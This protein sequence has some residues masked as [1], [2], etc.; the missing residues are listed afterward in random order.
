MRASPVVVL[1][2]YDEN[3]EER[4]LSRVASLG[5]RVRW[6]RRSR[7]DEPYRPLLRTARPS[8]RIQN[9]TLRI[10]RGGIAG[11]MSARVLGKRGPIGEL[12]QASDAEAKWEALVEQAPDGIFVTDLEGRYIEVNAAGCRMLGYDHDELI[13]KT[14]VDLIPPEDV[15]RLWQSRD[16]L[17]EGGTHVGEWTLRTKRGTSFPVEVS[18]RILPDGRWQGLVRDISERRR[19]AERADHVREGLLKSE[20]RF[21]LAFEEAPIGMALVGLDGS[22]VR[23]NQA[24]CE[25]VGYGADELTGRTFQEITYPADLDIDLDLANRLYRGEIPRYQLEKRYVRKDGAIVNVMLSGSMVRDP[26][27]EPL[28]YIAQIEDITER[29][30]IEAEQRFLAEAGPVLAAATMDYEQT[31][32]KIAELAVRDLADVCIVDVVG[33]DGEVRRLQVLDRT[34]NMDWVRDALMRIPLDRKRPHL[35]WSALE[36]KEP[37]LI[38]DVTPGDIAQWAQSDEHFRALRGLAAR[39]VITV[40]LLAH[41]R[42]LGALTLVSSTRRYGSA[43]LRLA[44]ELAHRAALSIENA[45]LYLV[46]KQAVQTRDEVLGIVAHDLRNPLNSIVMQAAALRAVGHEPC[47]GSRDPADVIERASNYMDRLIRDLLDLTSIDAGRLSIERSQ[48]PTR[49][50]LLDVMD[51]HRPV[52]GPAPIELRLEVASHLPDVWADPDRLVQVLDN[53]LGNALKFTSAGGRV[54]VGASPQA[55][56]VAFWVADTGPGIPAVHVP[57][58]FDRFWQAHRGGRR[59]AGLGLPI[60]K[61]I[62]QA[63]G[64]RIW[65]DTRPDRGSTFFFTIPAA[66]P[67]ASP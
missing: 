57:H 13:G 67:A 36:R 47:P 58:L 64:G 50:I 44:E 55:G 11:N 66:A 14:I 32:R 35:V 51:Q 33:E 24:L 28:Q 25:I 7:P 49:E 62:V 29:K 10:L 41:G 15:A 26:A 8:L 48:L 19:A 20:E 54:T 12:T 17:L 59:G 2:S 37:K 53:L 52:A 9:V 3:H 34:P 21:R 43:D 46:A 6:A 1:Q 23:V 31:L 4:P 22:F 39:S 65:V 30:R 61:G 16:Q 42:L 18:A 63:H 45:R 40:P 38:E 56:E 60:A 27:G 5:G